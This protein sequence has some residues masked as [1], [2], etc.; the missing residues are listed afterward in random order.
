MDTLPSLGVALN[1]R[2]RL[3]IEPM[4]EWKVVAVHSTSGE[5]IDKCLLNITFMLFEYVQVYNL[6]PLYYVTFLV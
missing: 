6:S 2:Y 1:E 3:E 5:V 4:V